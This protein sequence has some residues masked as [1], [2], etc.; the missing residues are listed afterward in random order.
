MGYNTRDYAAI[1]QLVSDVLIVL[2]EHGG[3]Q[4]TALIRR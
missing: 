2:E 3:D 4:A 1:R